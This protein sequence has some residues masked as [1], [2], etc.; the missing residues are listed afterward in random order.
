MS[1]LFETSV[2]DIIVDLETEQCPTLSLNFLKLCKA[3]K[4]NFCSFHNVIQDFIAQ[5]GDPTDTG[6]G[7]ASIFHQ[8]PPSSPAYQSTPYFVPDAAMKLKHSAYGT[9]SMAVAGEGDQ[10]GCGSQFFFTLAENLDYLDGKHAP[11]G[12]VVEGQET[13]AKINEALTDQEGRPLRDIRIRHVIVLDDP[14]DDPAGFDAP[15]QSPVPTAKQLASLRVGDE[16]DLE[17]DGDPDE[18]AQKRRER[19]A[20]AQALTLEM[21]GDLP[22]AD[23]APPENVLFVCK[24]NAVT[25]SEDLE[26]IFSRFG[27]ILSCEIIKD[28]KTGDSLQ[29]AFIEFRNQEDAERAYLKMDNVLVDDRRI[30]VDFSQSVSK[31]H[32]TWVYNRT[33]GRAPPNRSSRGPQDSRRPRDDRS[34]SASGSREP[35]SRGGGGGGR[36]YGSSRYAHR[37]EGAHGEMVFDL[38]EVDE[39]ARER[40]SSYRERDRRGGDR[41]RDGYEGVCHRGIYNP[42]TW[43]LDLCFQATTLT[44]LPIA[45]LAVAGGV[46]FPALWRRYVHGERERLSRQ[47]KAAYALKLIL[48][49]GLIGLQVADAVLIAVDAHFAGRGGKYLW[50][51]GPLPFALLTLCAYLFAYALET[52]SHPLLPH[53]STPLLFWSLLTLAI[54]TVALRSYLIAPVH[55]H[56][57]RGPAL[58]EFIVLVLRLTLMGSFFAIELL[59]PQGWEGMSWRDFVPFVEGQGKIRLGETEE[60]ER[61]DEFGLEQKECPRLRANIFQRLTFSWMTPMMKTG[62]RKFLTEEDLW[63]LPPDDTA[64]ALGQRLE[65]AWLARRAKA[66][67][68]S[69]VKPTI[70]GQQ[71][72][73]AVAPAD[74]RQPAKGD[75]VRKPSL[76]GALVASYG[77]P[78]F[79]A[80]LFKG[81]QDMLAFLQPWLL[82]RLLNFVGSYNSPEGEPAFHGYI[83]A[84]GMFCCAITQ[85]MLL[86]CYFSR[87]F[88]TGMRVRAGLVSLIYKKALVLSPSERGGRLTGD[89][90]NL[91]STDATRLQ[92][93]CTYGQIAWS[94]MFQITL[95]FISLYQLLGWTMLVGV[96]VMVAS[97]P[98]TALIARYQTKLQRQQM[99]NKDERTSIMSEILNN[100][101]SIKLYAWEN[102]FA[103]RLFQVRNDKELA[104]LKKMGILSASSNFLWSFTPFAV[105]FTTFALFSTISGKPLTSEIVFPAITLFQLLGFPLA[106]LPVVFSSLVEAYVSVDRL[107]TFLVSKELDPSAVEIKVPSRELRAGD[108]L[109]SVVQGDFTWSPLPSA[110]APASTPPPTNTLQDISLSVKR[111]EL[112]AVVGRVGDGKSSLLAAI[113]GEMI[114]VDGRVTVR[115]TVA[116][117][118]QQPWIMGGTVKSNITFGHRFEPEFYQLVLEA[119]ALKEDLKLLPQGDETEVGEKGISLSGGQKARVA[120]AR[121]V[122]A[123]ADIYLL[124]DPLSAVDAHV[125]RHLYDRVIGPEG[126][127]RDR[128]RLL[129]TNAIPYVEQADEVIMLRRGVILERG[130][131]AEAITGDTELSRLLIEFGKGGNEEDDGS[132]SGS[133]ETAVGEGAANERRVNGND[134]EKMEEPK[135]DEATLDAEDLALKLKMQQSGALSK[136]AEPI[137][138]AEQKMQTLR[139]LKRSTRP[140]ERREQ[141][142]VKWSVYKEYIKANGYIG[143]ILYLLTIVAQ[144]GLQIATNVWLKNW[145]QHNSDTGE[146]GD[147]RYYLAIYALLGVGASI[148]FFLNGVLL[149]SLCVIRSAKLMHDRMFNAVIRSPMLFFETTPLGTILNR[150]S[151]DVYVI[152]EVLA[153]V[154]GGFARTLAGV[155]GMVAVISTSAPAFLFILLPLLVIYKRVQTYYLATSRELKRLD[156][157][158]KSPIFASFQETLGGVSTIRAYRQNARFVAENEARVDRNQEAYFPSIN[159]NRWLAIRLEFIGACLILSTALL[160]V[161]TLVRTSS[162]NAGV[163]GLM[164]SYA[165][166]TTQTLNWIVRSATEVETNIVSV[167]R[168]QEYIDLPS[169]AALEKPDKKPSDEWPQ[170]GSIRFDRV[171][172]RYRK[173][174]DLV[175]RDVN[176][177][178]KAGEKVGVCGRTGAGKSSLTM[179]L[180][181]IIEVESGTVSIDGVDVGE[182]GLHDL[183]SRLSIIPQ[184]SQMFAGSLRQNLDPSGRATDAQMWAA[185]EQCRLKEHVERMEG[186]LDAHI[187]EGGTNFSAGQR[188]LICLGR[189]LLRRSKILVLDEATAAVDVES[190]RD[191]QTVIRREFASCTIFVIAHRLNTIMDCD[192]IL[193]MSAGSVAEFDTPQNLLQ[194]PESIFRSMATEAGLVKSSGANT[195]RTNGGKTPKSGAMTPARRRE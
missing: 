4:Y 8:L 97:M 41:D 74:G 167:E 22:F 21:V 72:S 130:T 66:V 176:F 105:A 62:Y 37:V 125:G 172:A 61:D 148:V 123:R 180:Y 149:Y 108:E 140:K 18:L 77:G 100:I 51:D 71:P 111:G 29:Y 95:A 162:V 164:L 194:Q 67:E 7:G 27:E 137:P 141:G 135:L 63:S 14:Y 146:N 9:L 160:A 116:Y 189:A 3:F 32:D 183:R 191:I 80:A 85:T 110:D 142:S 88:E 188:Q 163:V 94:G 15:E 178:I 96:G 147:V 53:A 23:V 1:V 90:V 152:D 156:A 47:G 57:L 128:A 109:V 84:L 124:D 93:L 150:F 64:Y 42:A 190:D 118:A 25:T 26:L 16:E 175:L 36:D 17:E 81:G 87:V 195:P 187:D 60:Q 6:K 102:S 33:G 82:K 181:R 126:L 113:L 70:P 89:I 34:Q 185:L 55:P 13:L 46:E 44:L 58:G 114:K 165:L 48:L 59:G 159:C 83:I 30:H 139:E 24:L 54:K 5:T 112:L 31:L 92:D 98:L 10:R 28:Q 151:R 192:K 35:D 19:E 161:T 40:N 166:S 11:F 174:L 154:F 153:R 2:G 120:L 38:T 136:R 138:V 133:D 99:K 186:K 177:E 173:D 171:D 20:R 129:C 101:R 12:R 182:L 91:Q 170:H 78:F 145:S 115:G 168:V 73:Y 45:V 134:E 143:A 68:K 157:T 43:D 117:C 107:T 169:E 76:T 184:D 56:D 104:M 75:K 144:Q 179:V 155:F 132:G 193:V 39:R 69:D 65:K 119:C 127:L 121:A 131:Y 50:R 49:V 52:A 106:V 103:Q 158:T 79:T 122:Y 86:H